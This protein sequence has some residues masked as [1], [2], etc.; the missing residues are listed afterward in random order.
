M[1]WIFVMDVLKNVWSLIR[2]F[3]GSSVVYNYNVFLYWGNHIPQVRRP[4]LFLLE[5]LKLGMSIYQVTNKHK[6][7]KRNLQEGQE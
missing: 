4:K 1:E 6:A 5:Q 2:F 7:H 3:V